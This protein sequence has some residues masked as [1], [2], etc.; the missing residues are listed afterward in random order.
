[1]EN[2]EQFLRKYDDK[3]GRHVPSQTGEKKTPPTK[4]YVEFL[5]LYDLM[6]R[7]AKSK[8]YSEYHVGVC[9]QIAG[10]ALM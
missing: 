5:V 9:G 1:M 8:T 10:N 2:L 6:K 7:E 3:Y 4:P